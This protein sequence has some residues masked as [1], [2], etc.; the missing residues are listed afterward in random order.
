VCRYGDLESQLKASQ[1]E[2]EQMQA[3]TDQLHASLEQVA[4]VSL[5]LYLQ[6]QVGD[7]SWTRQETGLKKAMATELVTL[8][9]KTKAMQ[10]EL[11][12]LS[13]V[14]FRQCARESVCL[15]TVA[16][17]PGQLM[18]GCIQRKMQRVGTPCRRTA[19]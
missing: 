7:V 1:G 15:F 12:S 2:V 11:L 10:S 5:S 8:T 17:L 18:N 14:A 4:F 19:G 16:S 3:L 9:S 13:G 6:E